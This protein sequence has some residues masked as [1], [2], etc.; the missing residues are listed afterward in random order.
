MRETRV[1]EREEG[2]I[3]R[4]CVTTLVCRFAVAINN[5]EVIRF[6]GMASAQGVA[7]KESP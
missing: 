3:K 1:D 7:G 2:N 4:C 5:R 6:E